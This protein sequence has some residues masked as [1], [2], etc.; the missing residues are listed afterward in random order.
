MDI[1]H[2][3][4]FSGIGGP[5]VAADQLGWVN[6]ISCEI[7]PF[8]NVVLN[9]YWPNA[10]HHDD[11]NTLTY[12]KIEEE[13]TKRFGEA[14]RT[15]TIVLSGGFPCQGFSLAGNRLG[16]EDTRYL[17]PEMLRIIAKLKPDYVIGENVTGILS[18]ED[19][20]GVLKEVFPEM[21]SRTIV[22][23]SE[24]DQYHAIY[25]RQAKMLIGSICE[26]LEERGYQVQPVVIP[27]ASIG[28]PHRR[29][30]TWI[31]ANTDLGRKKRRPSKHARSCREEWLQEWDKVQQSEVTDPIRPE[32][33]STP[34]DTKSEET[35]TGFKG[36]DLREGQ[37]DSKG[38]GEVGSASNTSS[39]GLEN[40]E[41]NGGSSDR[42]SEHDKSER[43]S[44]TGMAPDTDMRGRGKQSEPQGEE[45]SVSGIDREEGRCRMPDGTLGDVWD[46]NA[47]SDFP[48]Q[49]PLLGGDDGI[50]AILD[51]D[52]V[53]KGISQGRKDP[54]NHW[55]REAVTAYGNAIVPIVILQIFKA[56][57]E[58]EKA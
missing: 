54:Y 13:L 23:H 53:F 25:T 11:I 43:P 17:W 57:N 35:D 38:S 56:I 26:S 18:M 12:E 19:R 34:A 5:D 1:I 32:A 51:S 44:Y 49:P 29:D 48:T 41:Q 4:L 9:Y 52:A 36:N 7:N 30:R 3:S 42:E 8:P 37:C 15:A 27:A 46:G 39:K 55:R 50:S 31:I 10:Y 21:V 6:A 22:R 28:A 14:W 2:I 24:V 58:L 16:T 45:E 33:P 47:W 40:G 20:S